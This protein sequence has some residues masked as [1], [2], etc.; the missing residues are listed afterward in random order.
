MRSSI[1]LFLLCLFTLI[2]AENL[3]S[4]RN[5]IGV[6]LILGEPTGFS[7]K[8]WINEFEAVDVGIAY[9]FIGNSSFSLHADYL[10]HDLDMIIDKHEI[11]VYYGFGF[12]Y[13]ALDDD[14]AI[15]ARGVMGVLWY[16]KKYPIDVFFEIAPVFE[17]FPSTSLSF[18]IAIGGRYY[19]K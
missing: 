10:Y 3:E 13:R 9:S 5:R 1:V 11:P 15:G 17:L 12:R 4:S 16:D 14:A 6:G 2:S 8:Y 19:F 7:G 18:D